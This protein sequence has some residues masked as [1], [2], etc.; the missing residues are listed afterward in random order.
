MSSAKL[1][2]QSTVESQRVKEQIQ[3]AWTLTV[4]HV[5]SLGDEKLV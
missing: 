2:V 1:G 3:E 4:T 5:R